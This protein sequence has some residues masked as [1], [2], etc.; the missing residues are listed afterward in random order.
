MVVRFLPVPP[1]SEPE[2]R[3]DRRGD[4]PDLAEVIELR[5]RL[6][7]AIR[8]GVETQ[9][10][11]RLNPPFVSESEIGSEPGIESEYAGEPGFESESAPERSTQ[12]DGVRLLARRALSSGELRR[13]LLNI[14]HPA[15]DIDAAIDEFVASL[16]LDDLGLARRVTES[17]RERKGSSRSQIRMKLRDRLIPQGVIEEV[18]G[19]LDDDEEFALLRTAAAERAR[20][21]SGLDRQTAERRLLGFLA[22]RGWSGEPASRAAREALDGLRSGSGVRF[23]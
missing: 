23:Q 4:R 6:P 19:E 21:M 12:E 11:P 22:R 20:K 5:S 9:Y 13:D 17:L 3:D 8:A 10:A 15:W 14:G 1:A 2:N 18:L 16:Y 7:E